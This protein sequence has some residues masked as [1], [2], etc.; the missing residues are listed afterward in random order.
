MIRSKW[1]FFIAAVLFGGYLLI[2]LGAPL[3]PVALGCA[4]AALLTWWKQSHA[5]SRSG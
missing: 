1:K 4:G 5:A 2:S 3:F